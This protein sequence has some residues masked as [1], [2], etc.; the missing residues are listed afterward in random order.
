M[1][2]LPTTKR[3]AVVKALV[4]GCSVR[5]TCRLTGVSKPTVLKL[6]ADLGPACKALHDRIAR[7][8]QTKRVEVDEIW[9]FCGAKERNV[10]PNERRYGR[11]SIWTW[12]AVDADSKLVVS[13]HVGLRTDAD[14]NLFVHDIAQRVAGRIQLSS[15]GYSHY[16]R[17]VRF[18]FGK[19][20]IDYGQTLKL[21]GTTPD[22]VKRPEARYSPGQC[23][24]CRR[25]AVFGDPDPDYVSTSIAERGNLHLRMASRRFTRLTNAFSRKAE[26]LSAAVSLHYAYF[27]LCR[28]HSSIRCTPAM[29]AGVT[30]RVWS[31]EDLV[32]LLG[33]PGRNQT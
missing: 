18:A 33:T 15:D 31:V 24:S 11:G 9:A 27:N 6:L 20:G 25:E 1:N 13:W 5:S 32:N 14:A 2:I 28:I 30:G 23:L 21:F 22:S 3:V 19:D 29:K 26:N 7:N 4:E 16:P 10:P 17:A 12:A 8:L